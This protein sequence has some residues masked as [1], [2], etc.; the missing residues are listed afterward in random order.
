MKHLH[1]DAMIKGW[2]VGPFAPT[3]LSTS[4][5]EVAVKKYHKG[6]VEAAHV[7]RV[8]AEVTLIL[9]GRVRMGDREWRAGDIIALDPG[10]VTDFEALDDSVTVVVKVP[11]V[12]GDKYMV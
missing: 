1:L 12:P 5:C 10:D 6:D 4:S 8:A 3:A 2:F 11:G 7:H 9:S